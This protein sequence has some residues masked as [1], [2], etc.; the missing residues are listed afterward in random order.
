MKKSIKYVLGVFTIMSL[1]TSCDPN[2]P[3]NN[4]QP[5][6]DPRDNYV[7]SWLCNEHSNLNGNSSFSVTISLNPNN[8]TQIH[9]LNFYQLSGQQVYG[10]VTSNSVTIPSQQITNF[11]VKGTGTI[12]NNYTKIDWN[13][14]VNDGSD[15]D[16]CTA[17]FTK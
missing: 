1:L 9:L 16:T 13:Y 11:N 4:P 7:G 14:Y 10:V 8:S 2:D 12:S 17:V 5:I 3:N 15:I 6:D